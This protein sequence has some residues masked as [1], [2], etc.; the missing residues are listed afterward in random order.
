[1]TMPANLV[2]KDPIFPLYIALLA[3][4]FVLAL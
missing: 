3:A 2:S 1:M 4:I